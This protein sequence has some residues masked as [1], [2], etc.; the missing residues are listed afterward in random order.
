MLL[1]LIEIMNFVYKDININIILK[2]T[3]TN[4]IQSKNSRLKL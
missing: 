3:I 2:T 4:E 1:L